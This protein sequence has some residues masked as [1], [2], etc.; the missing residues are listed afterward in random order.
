MFL[1]NDMLLFEEQVVCVVVDVLFGGGSYFVFEIVFMRVGEDVQVWDIEDFLCG[2]F[3]IVDF[4]E[5]F[6]MLVVDVECGN[7]VVGLCGEDLCSLCWCVFLGSSFDVE[8][9][10]F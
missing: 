1:G 3:E 7:V 5:V 9:L 2:V 8:L 4:V 6:W 10:V